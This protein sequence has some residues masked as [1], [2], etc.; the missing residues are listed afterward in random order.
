[1]KKNIGNFSKFLG[2]F[3]GSLFSNLV[4]IAWL[5]TGFVAVSAF[6]N[7]GRY[8]AAGVTFMVWFVGIEVSKRPISHKVWGSFFS[9]LPTWFVQ[10]I[11]VIMA[12]VQ[13]KMN[14]AVGAVVFLVLGFS[15]LYLWYTRRPEIFHFSISLAAPEKEVEA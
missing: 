11:L 9:Y 1:M 7:A 5:A 12:M 10:G 15:Q 3:F 6:L 14:Y 8:Y 13:M 2:S 4:K